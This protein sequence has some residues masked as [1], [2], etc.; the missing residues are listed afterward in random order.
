[1]KLGKISLA[2]ASLALLVTQLAIVSS[3]AARYLYLRWTGQR[4]WTRTMVYDPDMLMRGRYVSVQLMV[5]G[6]ENKPPYGPPA[7]TPSPGPVQFSARLQVEGGKLAAIRLAQS[8]SRSGAQM[9]SAWPGLTCEQMR[10]EV[11]VDFY[12]GEHAANPAEIKP[13][14]E[15][16]VEVTVPRKG[17]PQPIQLALK[18]GKTWKPLGLN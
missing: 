11:P 1:M 18:E 9:V 17:P 5:D 15:L 10:L 2:G 6:C 7:T 16:W 3:A 12:I 4:V 8:D 14:Q 13:G